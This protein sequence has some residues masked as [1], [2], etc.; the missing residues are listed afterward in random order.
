MFMV[1]HGLCRK[2]TPF[3]SRR[4]ENPFPRKNPAVPIRAVEQ[5]F[6]VPEPAITARSLNVPVTV[7]DG[8]RA[9]RHT[10]LLSDVIVNVK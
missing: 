3:L 4:R 7:L 2:R 6:M 9:F 1:F 5:P 10:T 8:L